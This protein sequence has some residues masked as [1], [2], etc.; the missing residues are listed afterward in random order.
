ML[1]QLCQQTRY[2]QYVLHNRSCTIIGCHFLINDLNPFSEEAFLI[3]PGTMF[4]LF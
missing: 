3:F 1:D 4:Q 2:R